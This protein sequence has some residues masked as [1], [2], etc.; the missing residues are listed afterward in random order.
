MSTENP[1]MALVGLDKGTLNFVQMV[2]SWDGQGTAPFTTGPVQDL[3]AVLC[4]Q[5]ILKAFETVRAATNALALIGNEVTQLKT[6][7]KD[8]KANSIQQQTEIV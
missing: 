7:L 2:K 6:R 8:Q 1:T 4:N 5:N 3:A